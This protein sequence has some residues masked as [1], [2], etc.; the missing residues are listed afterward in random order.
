M[1]SQKTGWF[2][3]LDLTKKLKL[4][5]WAPVA[6]FVLII[7]V[8]FA[9]VNS[10]QN[11]ADTANNRN[12][13]MATLRTVQYDVTD[14]LALARGVML[15]QSDFLKGLYDKR[16]VTFDQN[17]EKLIALY[18]N[19]PEMQATARQLQKNKIE[20]HR[21]LSQQIR[22]SMSSDPE[23]LADAVQMEK[24]GR[25]YPALE[26]VLEKIDEL[27]PLQEKEASAADTAMINA[28]SV[29]E[30][31][32]LGAAVV[33]F[34]VAFY[35]A[36]VIGTAVSVPLQN[37]TG[38]MRKVADNDLESEIPYT[39]RNDETGDMAKALEFFRDEMKKGAVLTAEREAA[40]KAQMEAAEERAEQ[41]KANRRRDAQEAQ[42]RDEQAARVDAL[43][44]NFDA[45]ISGAIAQLDGNA[46]EMQGTAN[47]MVDVANQTRSRATSVSEAAGDMQSNVATMA[48][49]IEEFSSSIREVSSQIQSAS[50][51]SAQAVQV[52]NTGSSA[53]S[54][55]STASGKIE[56]VVNL[57]NDIAEQTNLL[58]LNATIEAARAGDAGKG[59]AVVASEVKNLAN[60][61]A[62]AT[63]DITRQI[64]EMQG[65]TKD[66]V[67][68][69]DDIDKEIGS[70][71]QVTMAVSA[72]IEEQEAATAEISRSVQFA[73]EKT[74]Q[75]A[76][77]IQSVTDGA[78]RTGEASNSVQ[79]VSEQLEVLSSDI[80]NN[81]NQFLTKVRET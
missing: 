8:L 39:E 80:T 2:N 35:L 36:K 75:V 79:A 46:S 19:Q 32:L 34:L 72:A 25:S 21:I 67:G 73:A 31:I 14:M 1:D 5:Q 44:A 37:I 10:V 27:V 50:R 58:A 22:Q 65:L 60:Q 26:A 13:S 66:V 7:A 38:A 40:Q 55:L 3:N 30:W 45:A 47:G 78:N 11:S 16:T 20:L 6:L 70:L 71:N 57:I 24:D 69:M 18:E 64:D 28:F 49:A 77:E 76:S 43:V 4:G 41:E 81:V 51:M 42:Q 52:A 61:T 33:G 48:S 59:F 29:Q 15:T 17:I 56:D 9:Q 54:N 63:E 68:A 12:K 74:D 23:Q 53:I 62:K